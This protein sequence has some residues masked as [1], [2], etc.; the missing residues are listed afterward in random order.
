MKS[1]DWYSERWKNKR[2]LRKKAQRE[3]NHDRKS[4]GQ[5]VND[6]EEEMP[7]LAVYDPAEASQHGRIGIL[8]DVSFPAFSILYD[9]KFLPGSASSSEQSA[10]L[11]QLAVGDNV[12]FEISNQQLVIKGITTRHSKL[13]RLRADASRRSGIGEEHVFAVN[14]DLAV[15]VASTVNPVFHPRLVDRYLIICQYGNIRPLLCLTKIDIAPSPDL[16]MYRNADLPIVSVSNKTQEGIDQLLP[17]LEGKRCVLVGNSG[18]GK[19][20]LINSLLKEEAILT[21]EVSEK[22]GK[23]RHTTT[24]TSLH[25]L[26]KSTMLIDTP[27][28]RSLGLW[29]VSPDSLRLYYPEFAEFAPRCEFSD[30]THSHEPKC[31]VKKAVEEGLIPRERYNSYIRLLSKS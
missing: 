9:G 2:A 14:I 15:I 23:G 5:K 31:A 13:A 28:I 21:K 26:D 8:A 11:N 16:S 1:K 29:N 20:S 10:L 7:E 17:Y 24:S 30:C 3:A 6:Q 19:S 18:V 12:V 25:L 27:G 4:F 22:S